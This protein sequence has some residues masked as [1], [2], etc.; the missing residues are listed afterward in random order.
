VTDLSPQAWNER[1]QSKDT[2]W[3]LSGPTPEFARI[4]DAGILPPK[5]RV[6]VPGGGRGHDAILFNK[7]GY[8]VD[9]VDFAPS[10]I[11]AA[12]LEC[13]RQKAVVY[14]YTRDFFDLP[15][16]GYHQGHYDV[17]LEYTFFCAINPE[18][19]EAYVKTAAAL[20]RTGGT[21]LGLFFPTKID[22]AG[23]PFEVHEDEVRALFSPYFD[24]KIEKPQQSVKP[25][26]G[27][28]FLGIFTR[29]K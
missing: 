10:A 22:K 20:L 12:L 8:E 7:R 16:V 15:N 19:R 25:R 29:K 23:P 3:D 1:Y 26:E 18:K 17:L 21:L 28:E 11:E 13:S 2:P 14:T 24:V 9:L 4:L 5:G 27:R 6:L